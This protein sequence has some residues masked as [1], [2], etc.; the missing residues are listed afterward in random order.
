MRASIFLVRVSNFWS[1]FVSA[2]STLFSMAVTC[3]AV[4]S[5]R[6]AVLSFRAVTC[7]SVLSF[8]AFTAWPR[9]AVA[10]ANRAATTVKMMLVAVPASILVPSVLMV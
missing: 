2:I 4:L 5:F 6:A 7:V 3:D 8:R 1:K 9:K 10:D